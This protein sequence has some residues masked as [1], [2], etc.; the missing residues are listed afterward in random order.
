MYK[1]YSVRIVGVLL[2]CRVSGFVGI[3]EIVGVLG[4]RVYRV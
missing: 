2:G 1:G 4:F 3:I